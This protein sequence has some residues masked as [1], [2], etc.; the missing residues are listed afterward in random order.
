MVKQIHVEYG[1]C[2]VLQ[3]S[4]EL[5][6]LDKDCI[7]LGVYSPPSNSIYYKDCEIFN[8]M[9]L[10]ENCIFDI[11]EQHGQLPFL[12]FGDLN[13]RTGTANANECVLD[14][15]NDNEDAQ[16]QY[17]RQSNSKD[18]HTNDFGRYLLCIGEQFNLVILNGCLP[19]DKE[20]NY[21]YIARNGS[22]VSDYFLLSRCLVHLGTRLAMIPN[23]ESKHMP[24][25]LE[26]EL[27]GKNDV[28]VEIQKY[29]WDANKAQNYYDI[30]K[31]TAV[32]QFVFFS[33]L[34]N[35]LANEIVLKGTLSPYI[36]QILIRLF[37]DDVVLLSNTIVGLQ[38][39]LSV[40][41]D[42]AKILHLVV[43]FQKS[44]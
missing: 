13:A 44:K 34:I 42:T 16:N 12:V 15:E 31:G 40:L 25:K 32:A 33:L 39:Q 17:Y 23:T 14:V 1:Y 7:L 43:N 10:V 30:F 4:K 38:Q 11:I 24:E 36:L 27:V 8:G 37:T 6:G 21:T 2:V 26:L 3:L 9:S 35:E 41:R 20:G 22:S 18:V 28:S 5:S 19:G 29:I